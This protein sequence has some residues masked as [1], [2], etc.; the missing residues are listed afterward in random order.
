MGTAKNAHPN[1]KKIRVSRYLDKVFKKIRCE[2]Q[3][4]SFMTS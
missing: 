3:F 2:G 4:G 1:L